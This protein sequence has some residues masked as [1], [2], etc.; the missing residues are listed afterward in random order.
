MVR[1]FCLLTLNQPVV[2]SNPP[3]PIQKCE[4]SGDVDES[5]FSAC[6]SDPKLAE[7][8]KVWPQLPE[9]LKAAIQALVLAEIKSP[10]LCFVVGGKITGAH[11]SFH[12]FLRVNLCAGSDIPLAVEVI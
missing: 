12:I 1:I 3:S 7:I 2:G 4:F 9:H 6:F 8:V 5:L 10:C 11:K